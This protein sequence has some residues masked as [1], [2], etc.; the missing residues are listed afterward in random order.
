[1]FASNLLQLENNVRRLPS[2]ELRKQGGIKQ[3][4]DNR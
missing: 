1:M 2:S 4:S 3:D